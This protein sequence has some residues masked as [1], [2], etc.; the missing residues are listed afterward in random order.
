MKQIATGKGR[1]SL[2]TN[3][4]QNVKFVKRHR[5]KEEA[6]CVK[7]DNKHISEVTEMSIHDAQ[8]WF[9]N[10]NDVLDDRKIKIAEHILK[11]IMKDLT[12]C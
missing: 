10:L 9:K 7:I 4:I 6:L 1:K 11:E 5:L 3:L 2:S 12:F 8:K